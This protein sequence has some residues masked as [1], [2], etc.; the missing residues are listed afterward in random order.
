MRLV[1]HGGCHKTAST[2]FQNIARA[3]E[4]RLAGAGVIYPPFEGRVQHS[5]LVWRWQNGDRAALARVLR[6]A[7][8]KGGETILLSGED[9]E[10]ALVD[11]AFAQ[12]VEAVA[13]DAGVT[14]IDWLFVTRAPRDYVLSVYAELSRH[15]VVTDLNV[16][17]ANARERGCF[18]VS[19]FHLSQIFVFDVARFAERMRG[20]VEGSVEVMEME[21]F[22]AG[23]PGRVLLSRL[24]GEEVADA[25][26]A[27]APEGRGRNA[28][29]S[30]LE[31]ESRYAQSALGLWR[32]E[33]GALRRLAAGVLVGALARWRLAR[34]RR[35]TAKLEV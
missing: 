4:A 5:Q 23:F 28:R 15:N 26:F 3:G 7:V 10:N 19:T 18:S 9:F 35:Q 1:I 2:A 21:T 32:G 14:G 34:V 20:A 16:I 22:T 33:G 27:E 30:E 17:A 12:E 24:A 13:R 25:I 11:L 6:E 8:A 29:M 31:V